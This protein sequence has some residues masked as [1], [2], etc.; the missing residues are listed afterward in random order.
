MDFNDP[1]YLK[2]R[3]WEVLDT[4]VRKFTSTTFSGGGGSV[5]SNEFGGVSGHV[6]QVTSTVH[7]H[8]DQDIWLRNTETNEEALFNFSDYKIAVRPGHFVVTV[9]D[10][11]S[12]VGL[13]RI[14][15]V[16]TDSVYYCKGDFNYNNLPKL[17]SQKIS[18]VILLAMANV[19]I[20]GIPFAGAYFAS[21]IS[22]SKYSGVFMSKG[23]KLKI[24]YSL[25][26][27]YPA[28]IFVNVFRLYEFL[29]ELLVTCS[30]ILAG[31]YFFKSQID[32]FL[33]LQ[34]FKEDRAK[35][36]DQML[37]EYIKSLSDYKN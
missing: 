31:L 23:D 22:K 30:C 27:F 19:V 8:S 35:F 4:N 12:P 21:T 14:W 10:E 2:F 3:H 1:K 7:F 17:R 28:V 32:V 13:E 36:I 29:P 20:N 37:S 16:N 15:V 24:L 9:D 11:L 5:Q 6:N 33:R 26:W 25:I 18:L 34:N